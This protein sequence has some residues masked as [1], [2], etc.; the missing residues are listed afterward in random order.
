MVWP[1]FRIRRERWSRRETSSRSSAETMDALKAQWEATSCSSCGGHT[2]CE[3]NDFRNRVVCLKS[4]CPLTAPCLTH[5]HQPATNSRA[6]KVVNVPV[7]ITTATGW[8][9]LPTRFFP[10]GRFT[11]VLPPTDESIWASKVVGIWIKETPRKYI[12]A[13]K[14]ATSP[15]TPPPN[16]TTA[17]FRS[18]PIALRK[19][20]IFSIVWTDLFFSPS[21]I[22][23][24]LTWKPS[25]LRLLTADEP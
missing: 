2:P 6:G 25:P 19:W 23:N 18:S 9:K 10:A 5:S 22:K 24:G 12:A 4:F 14:P 15:T 3:S 11:P 8:W 17:S 13:A 21:P 1:K 20:R 7:S 16:A